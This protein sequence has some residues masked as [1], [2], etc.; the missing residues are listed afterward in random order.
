MKKKRLMQSALSIALAAALAALSLT[1][2]SHTQ[3]PSAKDSG[4]DE[5]QRLAVSILKPKA[6]GE[7][8][9][10]DMDTVKVMSEKFNLEFQIDNPPADDFS[11]KL[12]LLLMEEELPDVIMNIPMTD[13]VKYIDSGRLIPLNDLIKKSMPNLS[14]MLEKY[15]DVKRSISK[16][17]GNIYYFPVIREV[18]SGNQPYIVRTD[19]LAQLNVSS[20]VTIEDWERLWELVKTTDLNGNGKHDEI[21]FSAATMADVRNFCTAWG[22]LDDFYADPEDGGQIHY[23]PIEEKYRQAV[24]WMHDMW[25]KGYID[26]E[27]VS[28]NEASFASKLS[29]NVVASLRGYLGANMVTPNSKMP[30]IVPGYRLDA[31]CPP[32]GPEGY[33][34]HSAIDVNP[35]P[36]VGGVIS[37]SCKNAERIAEWIDFAYSP[38]GILLMNMGIEGKHYEMKDGY[39]VLTDFVMHNPDGL[40]PGQAYGTYTYLGSGPCVANKALIDQIDDEAVV[41]AKNECILPYI[42]TSNQ[43]LVTGKLSFTAEQDSKRTAIMGDVQTYVDEMIMKFITGK[44]PLS[45]WDAYVAAVKR[46][47]IDDAIEIYQDAYN[48]WKN[49]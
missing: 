27:L 28:S 30:E 34:I 7:V 42:E 35:V 11:S 16:A 40:S 43:Y 6:A 33:Q 29:L 2:C 47:N 12:N 21:P 17:D 46:M 39:P 19:W 5:G 3:D 4:L 48:A 41:K 45:H 31:T 38:E 49:G 44:E 20:P 13:L 24:Q 1:G 15:P 37:T 9:M 36:V 23:G 8:P 10:A 25:D 22:V 18:S 26:S 14:A 32:K